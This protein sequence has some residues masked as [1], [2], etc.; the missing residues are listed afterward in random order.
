[1]QLEMHFSMYVSLM[2]KGLSQLMDGNMFNY[3]LS[4]HSLRDFRP[5][6]SDVVSCSFTSMSGICNVLHSLEQSQLREPPKCSDSW[7]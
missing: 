5:V 7:T 6:Q 2:I 1:M 3:Y 4:L